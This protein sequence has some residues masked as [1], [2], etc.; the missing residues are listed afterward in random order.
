V[1][2]P[3]GTTAAGLEQLSKSDIHIKN[4]LSTAYSRANELGAKLNEELMSSNKSNN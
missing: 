4:C 1:V 2:T 3:N